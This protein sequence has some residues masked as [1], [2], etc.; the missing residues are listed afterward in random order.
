MRL[1]LRLALGLALLHPPATA[2]EPKAPAI[3]PEA[4]ARLDALIA[5]YRA[6]PAYADHGEVTLVVKVGDRELKQVQAASIAFARPNKLDVRTNFVR[7]VSDGSTVTSS[8]APLKK[9]RVEPAPKKFAESSFRSGPLGSVEFGGIAGLPLV[10]ALSLAIGD[11]PQR[12][13]EDFSPRVLV[14]PDREVDGVSYHV[15]RLDESDNHDWRYL[16]DPKT[17]LLAAIE[18]VVEGD[19]LK[20]SIAGGSTH[21]E[22][23]RWVPGAISTEVPG[24]DVFAFKPEPGFTPVGKLEAAPAAK[25]E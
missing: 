9:Y 7:V 3:S 5:A 11:D 24:A 10:H 18:L 15:L 19:A 4:K 25:A 1:A 22:S 13:I 23:L 14:E 16:I 2:Q 12:L 6:L 8:V 17:G 21:V 20:S